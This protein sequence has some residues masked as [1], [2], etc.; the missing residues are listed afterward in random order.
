MRKFGAAVLLLL[1]ISVQLSAQFFPAPP[2][3]RPDPGPLPKNIHGVVQ[4]LRGKPVNGAHVFI[5]DLKTSVI[6]TQTTD[7]SGNY[8]IFALKPT[9]DYEVYAEFKGTK[10]ESRTVSGFV[11]RQDNVLNFQLDV[12]GVD[13]NGAANENRGPEFTTFD[14]VRLHASLDIPSGVNAPIPAVLLLHG[15]G[16]DRTVWEPLKKQ[17][18]D[19]GWAVLALDLRG[20]GESKMKD[21]VEIQA[22]TSWRTDPNQFPQD[23]SP[24]FEFIKAHTRLNNRK[25]AVV[26]S[27]VG[28]DLA[29]V[30]SGRFPEVRTVVAIKPK[31]SES[32]ALAGSSQDFTPHSVLILNSDSA[33]RSQFSGVLRQP[34][35]IQTLDI[36]GGTGAWI[37]KTPVTDAIFQWL[38]KTF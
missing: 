34:Y 7:A 4:D 10:S 6:R 30:A 24:A 29:L 16:E 31:L 18:L 21:G 28:A 37:A 27:D 35:D 11:N 25:I 15:Y 9:E 14:L 3:R 2:K 1:L 38:Q 36:S 17:L 22:S 33:E 19:H 13:T 5:K 23:L 32:L 26:G 8:Q 20:H 12:A